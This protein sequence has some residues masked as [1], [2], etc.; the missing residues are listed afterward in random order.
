MKID[1]LLAIVTLL[2]QKGAMT[3]PE[4]AGRL[5][6]SR[7]TIS[8][9]IDDLC[10][11]GIPVVTRQ[12]NG[13]GISIAEGYTIDKDL[14]TRDELEQ[15]L[16]GLGG[17]DSVGQLGAGH[18]FDKLQAHR[19]GV[20]K[21][22]GSIVIDLASHYKDSLSY[23]IELIRKGVREGRRIRFDYYSPKGKSV[24]TVEPSYTIF[25]WNNWYL[26]GYCCKRQ[27][28]RLFKL[29]RLWNLELLEER[30]DPKEVPEEKR[31]LDVYFTDRFQLVAR[32][33]PKTAYL[34]IEEY[35]PYCYSIE[36]DGRLLLKSGFTN[37]DVLLA[38]LLSFGSAVEVLEP[39]HIKEALLKE[40][41]LMWN[42]YS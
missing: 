31:D 23:K 12:G 9:D 13:G 37:E 40:I 11:A 27:D 29:P 34:L 41:C 30:F 36:A 35:G 21:A 28:F 18:L 26:L 14:L 19:Q 25:K 33:D 17:L 8:R 7:R 20:Y 2:L 39:Q 42:I 6:V 22:D 5:E 4:L 32:F 1:R 15:I 3:A 38:W 24:R 10:K 16:I